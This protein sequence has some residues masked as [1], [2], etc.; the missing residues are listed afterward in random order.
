MSGPANNDELEYTPLA[1]FGLTHFVTDIRAEPHEVE[2][3]CRPRATERGVEKR[4]RFTEAG[5]LTVSYRWD[6]ETFF[7]DGLFA[8]E[9]SVARAL[10]LGYSPTPDVWTFSI[11]TLSK[12][13][14]GFDESVQGHSLTPRW[15]TVLGAARV[16]VTPV[17]P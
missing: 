1:A 8:P 13:E 14:R 10:D 12:S 5:A 6:P 4:I 9:I 15:P 7:P 16:E 11:T 3:V 17:Q 2:L